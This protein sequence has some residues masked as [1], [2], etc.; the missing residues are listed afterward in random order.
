MVSTRMESII[1]QMEQ[2]F[3]SKVDGLAMDIGAI[4]EE[5]KEI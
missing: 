5:L 4:K 2:D 3:L 1:E